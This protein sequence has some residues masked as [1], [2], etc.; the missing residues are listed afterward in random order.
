LE[1][2]TGGEVP[3]EIFVVAKDGSL[4]KL[5]PLFP[6]WPPVN[7]SSYEPKGR[8]I[9]LVECDSGDCHTGIWKVE[10]AKADE[11]ANSFFRLL[12]LKSPPEGMEEVAMLSRGQSYELSII[13]RNGARTKV[14]IKHL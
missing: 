6:E 9:Y 4:Q 8:I 11:L 5:P 12:K 13:L 14:I 7:F 3:T 1:N 2:K 10:A